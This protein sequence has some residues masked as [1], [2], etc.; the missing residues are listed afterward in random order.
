MPIDHRHRLAGIVDEQRLAGAVVLAHHQI[1]L[2]R[3]GAV[4]QAEPAVLKAQRVIGL[5]LLPKQKKG[6]ALAP[7]FPVHVRPVGLAALLGRHGRSGR[8]ERTLQRGIIKLS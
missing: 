6:H 7:Q 1:K 3:P 4:V 8:I 2:A 5:V